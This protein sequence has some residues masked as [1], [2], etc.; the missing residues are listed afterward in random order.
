M[1]SNI[2]IYFVIIPLVMLGAPGLCRNIKQIRAVAVVGSLGLIALSAVLLVQYLGLRAAESEAIAASEG[3][4]TAAP[5]LFVDSWTWFAPLN[6]HL[7]VGVDGVSIAMILLS[8]IIVF[9][10]SFASWKIDNM[11]H[12][13][14]WLLLLSTG[15]LRFLH[16]H[17]PLHHV[18]VLRGCTYPDVPPHRRMGLGPQELLG[19]EADPYAHGWFGLPDARPHRHILPLGSRRPAA[20]ME[21]FSR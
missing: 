11:R 15:V 13:F 4:L 2:L 1:F 21:P 5:M 18:Y 17:R 16:Q 12:F 10:G 20:D 8:S 9:A 3:A 19:H 7:A 6:I 14:M